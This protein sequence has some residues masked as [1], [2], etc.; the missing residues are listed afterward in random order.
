MN[1]DHADAVGLY[2][3]KLLGLAGTGWR[4]TGIDGEGIDLRR[5]GTVARLALPAPVS[6]PD[7]ARKALIALV[8]KARNA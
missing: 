7:E 1:D 5:G 4:I 2:A 3:A 8:A 6:G